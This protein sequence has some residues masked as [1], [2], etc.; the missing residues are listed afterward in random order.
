MPVVAPRLSAVRDDGVER[1]GEAVVRQIL[2]A[3]FVREEP[4]EA[5]TRFS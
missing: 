3:T 1:V 4:Y 2:G 5:P